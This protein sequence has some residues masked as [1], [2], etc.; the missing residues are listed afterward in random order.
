MLLLH[1]VRMADWS[2]DSKKLRDEFEEAKHK[3][4]IL[5][6]GASCHVL[7]PLRAFSD[8]K[9]L[10]DALM[11]V[12]HNGMRMDSLQGGQLADIIGR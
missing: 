12:N 11:G 8:N 7:P 5:A 4:V 1:W 9:W 2:D 6:H 10:D 3:K